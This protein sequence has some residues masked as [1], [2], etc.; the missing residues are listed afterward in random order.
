MYTMSYT[1][2]HTNLAIPPTLLRR[3]NQGR[4]LNSASIQGGN[5]KVEQ[6]MQI[7]FIENHFDSANM[8][9]RSQHKNSSTD[10]HTKNVGIEIVDDNAQW[11][12]LNGRD[13]E[14]IQ[15]MSEDEDR[16]QNVLD[17]NIAMPDNENVRQDNRLY[18]MNRMDYNKYEGT[19]DGNIVQCVG[20]TVVE[21][22]NEQT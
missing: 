11:D 13:E 22:N 19:G 18:G 3:P 5:N 2:G 1:T 4:Y 7:K 17:D 6:Q 10:V 12:K 20:V 15:N 16:M 9:R 8:N 21:E 14:E